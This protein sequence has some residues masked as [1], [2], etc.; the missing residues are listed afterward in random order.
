[1]LAAILIIL[2]PLA[3]PP[4]QASHDKSAIEVVR[5]SIVAFFVP[6][7]HTNQDDV[8]ANDSLS[9]FQ[10]YLKRAK[11]PLERAGIDIYEVYARSFR[12]STGAT[13]TTFQTKKA[14]VGYY[15][16]APG[17][18]PRVEYGVM[19]DAD[20]IKVATEYFRVTVK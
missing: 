19:T 13:T 4:L 5:P 16:V 8:H 7:R 1:M 15:L 14:G 9:D 20:L 18:K 17:N 11:D 12:I 2:S 3:S 6:P 10:L